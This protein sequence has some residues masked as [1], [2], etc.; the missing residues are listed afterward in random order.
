MPRNFTSA[1]FVVFLFNLGCNYRIFEPASLNAQTG[2]LNEKKADDTATVPTFNS[3]FQTVIRPD[4]LRCHKPGGRGE[5]VP[6]TS[7][8]D[9]LKPLQ[10]DPLIV[11]GDP[12][13]SL[14]YWVLL[15]QAGRKRMPPQRGGNAPVAD[16]KIQVIREWILQGAPE[17]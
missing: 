14:F 12:E 13:N 5:D 6:L 2:N 11:P 9:L 4:C 8:Q 10:G 1:L 7:Y 15:P 16:E 3:I 17:N